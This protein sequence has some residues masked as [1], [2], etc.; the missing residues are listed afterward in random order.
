M[1]LQL[2]W[3]SVGS[4]AMITSDKVCLEAGKAFLTTE[5]NWMANITS[6]TGA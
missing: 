4:T 5:K 1:A 2:D 6:E 3:L